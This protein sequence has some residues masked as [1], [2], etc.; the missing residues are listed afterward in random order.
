M[1][2]P[3]PLTPIPNLQFIKLGGSLITDKLKPHTPRLEILASLASEIAA[4]R[5]ARPDF[6]LVVGHGSGSFGHVPARRYGT[7]QGVH[8][9]QEWLGFAEV[10]LEAAALN[11]LVIDALA[12]AGLPV[13]SFPPSASAIAADGKVDTWELAPLQAALQ[14]GL[15]PV[16]QGDTIIDRVRGGT[17]L[18]TEDLFEHLAVQLRP[19]RILLAG[20]EP[21]VWADYPA[22]TQLIPEITPQN[23]AQATPVLDG[24]AATDVTGGMASKV[25]QSLALVEQVPGLEILIFSGEEPGAL[26]RAL[27]GERLGTLVRNPAASSEQLRSTL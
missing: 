5:A 6:R 2:L 21:G 26:Q 22:C 18:S 24:S 9:S 27:A 25:Q 16:I 10:W 12:A 3:L 7:R 11:R 13:I 8:T 20:I 19:E 1:P 23:F 14:A 17:I 4:T 15:L